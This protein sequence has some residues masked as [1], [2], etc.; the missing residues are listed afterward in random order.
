MRRNDFI[1][2]IIVSTLVIM[3]I[4][5]YRLPPQDPYMDIVLLQ[6]DDGAW[7]YAVSAINE[8]NTTSIYPYVRN[9]MDQTLFVKISVYGMHDITSLEFYDN[10][11]T[12]LDTDHPDMYVMQPEIRAIDEEFDS[13]WEIEKWNVYNLTS[14]MTDIALLVF[15]Y[16]QNIW[17]LYDWISVTII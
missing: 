5:I 2:L 1:R 14:S 9:I 16:D 8:H 17:I 3:I 13:L 6:P 7:T 15:H 4:Q 11:S 12:L 10:N